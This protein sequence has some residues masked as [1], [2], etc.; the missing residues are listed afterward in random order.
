MN[1]AKTKKG[2][3]VRTDELVL[4]LLLLTHPNS[5]EPWSG[6]APA[7]RRVVQESDPWPSP[8]I[9]PKQTLEKVTYKP[10]RDF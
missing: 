10:I 4:Y 8:S 2:N 6:A 9:C 3:S 5:G 1:T 7:D